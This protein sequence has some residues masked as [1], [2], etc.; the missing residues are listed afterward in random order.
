MIYFVTVYLHLITKRHT[1]AYFSHIYLL[2]PFAYLEILGV[3]LCVILG[4]FRIP[5]FNVIN[6]TIFSQKLD[7]SFFPI[8]NVMLI[9]LTLLLLQF[10]MQDLESG[11][12]LVATPIGNLEDITLRYLFASA[13]I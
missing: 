13:V 12:Y 1:D 2:L 6:F 8:R 3:F 10:D 9:G 7:F 4:S 5:Y 11:L